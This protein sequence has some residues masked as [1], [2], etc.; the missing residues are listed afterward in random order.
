[1]E[2]KRDRR[3]GDRAPAPPSKA[4]LGADEEEESDDIDDEGKTLYC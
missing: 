2:R 4:A 1:M 3:D